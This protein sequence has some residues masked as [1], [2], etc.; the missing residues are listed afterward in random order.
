MS[1]LRTGLISLGLL[2]LAL[3]PALGLRA[4][5]D[6]SAP[7]IA[8]TYQWER[9]YYGRINGVEALLYHRSFSRAKLSFADIDG[10]GDDDIFIGKE[11][12]RI[13]FFQNIGTPAKPEFRL[14][15]EDFVAFRIE[16][17]ANQQPVQLE[18]VIDV[19]SNAVPELIDMD[20]D[21]DL[22]LFIGSGDGSLF[23]YENRGNRI[24]PR[25]FL[26][27]PLYM[28]LKFPRNVVPRFADVNGDRN[29]DLLVGTGSGKVRLILNSGVTTRALFCPDPLPGRASDP[30]CIYFPQDIS[31][32]APLIDAA[33]NWVDWDRDGDLDIVVGKSNGRVNFL[34]NKGDRFTPS[35]ERESQRF[36]YI[37]TGGHSAPTFYDLDKDGFPELFL[38]SST[39]RIFLFE[40][41]EPLLS[42]LRGIPQLDL[43]NFTFSDPPMVLLTQ[44]CD[45]LR[46]N[47]ECFNV[48]APAFGQPITVNSLEA[49]NAEIYRP[50]VSLDST[51][52]AMP[53]KE[54]AAQA[55]PDAAAEAEAPPAQANVNVAEGQP[56]A[57][58]EADAAVAE[59][60]E[61]KVLLTRNR[62]WF[63]TRNFLNLTELAPNERHTKITSGD[64]NGDGRADLLVGS[65]S[66]RIYAY[67]NQNGETESNWVRREFLAFAPNQRRH[68]AP[69]LADLDGDGDLDV[70]VGNRS[71]RLELIL[72]K[73]DAKQPNW[74]VDDVHLF[75]I[76]V[77]N[78][79]LPALSDLDGDAD[80]DLL[81]GNGKGLVI[82]YEN[83]GNQEKPQFILRNTRFARSKTDG[84]AAPALFHWNEDEFADLVVGQRG[85]PLQLFSRTPRKNAPASSGWHL[86][87][88]A[89]QGLRSESHSTPHFVDVD[90][91]KQTDLL[92]GD[93]EGHILFW[94]NTGVQKTEQLP[95]PEPVLVSNTLEDTGEL[96]EQAEEAVESVMSKSKTQ[97]PMPPIFTL[98]TDQFGGIQAGRR[99][100]PALLDLDGDNDFDLLLGNRAG[101]L[102]HLVNE[103]GRGE[104]I[105]WTLGTRNFLDFRNGRY[106][107]PVVADL[108]G[109]A[110]P[111]LLVGSANGSI[112]YWEN[113]GTEQFP[114]FIANPTPFLGVTGGSNAVPAVL[115]LNNDGHSDLL[116]GNFEGNLRQ[117]IRLNGQNGFR[118]KLMHRR[119][120]NLDVGLGAV[121]HVADLNNDAQP[122]LVVGSDRGQLISFVPAKTTESSSPWG[123]VKNNEYFK[124]L[125]LPLGGYPAFADLDGDGDLD[126]LVGT[127]SGPLSYYR[128]DAQ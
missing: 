50:D 2:L 41:R 88:D 116:V 109:D 14:K 124:E 57:D 82:L 26:K 29:L 4:Q 45:Q 78:D 55:A 98:V 52:I 68:S 58:P 36:L 94:R 9:Q 83:K 31:S 39:S 67:E 34:L 44:A 25:L 121:P 62:L 5:Q 115:D 84:Y 114:D 95:E 42:G 93:E 54:A 104:T 119:F 92:M 106:S 19:G 18:E 13:A 103:G 120:L 49:L 71:G 21:G 86:E 60:E 40:N 64:W 70:V 112:R 90:N 20:S 15:M 127:E 30:N 23:H 89:W 46:G 76:D 110:D 72:N 101:E 28:N 24:L 80:L 59:P 47:P 102:L 75:Q 105:T 97:E 16:L 111:D 107:A 43:S 65:S 99:T 12:G 81:V 6:D 85:G 48:L 33:P 51:P 27:T 10:D 8:L 32:I 87:S 128:N 108:D 91:D 74:V 69:T 122:D 117:F 22:D 73:G 7:P 77:G 118:F 126:M 79:S 123:W 113:K 3:A 17:D 11:D 1:R 53:E 66:G 37:N 35:W 61:S 63:S 96:P 100:T 125:K 56:P 38:G